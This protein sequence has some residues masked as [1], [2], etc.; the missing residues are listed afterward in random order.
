M[1]WPRSA[2]PGVEIERGTDA[3]HSVPHAHERRGDLGAHA[4]EDRAGAHQLRHAAGLGEDARHVGVDHVEA[5]DVDHQAGGTA[6]LDRRQD[7]GLEGLGD[8]VTQLDLDAH[9]ERRADAQ[10]RD[11]SVE[12]HTTLLT[13]ALPTMPSASSMPSLRRLTVCIDETSRPSCT[14]VRATCAVIPVR[15]TSAPRRRTAAAV[16]SR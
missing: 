16:L 14:I 6:L 2:S 9:E 4:D 8:G 15:T 1:T 10:D 11:L 13:M 5:A 12:A 3:L 7:V